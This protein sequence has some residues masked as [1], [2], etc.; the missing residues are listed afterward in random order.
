MGKAEPGKGRE[1][2][3]VRTQFV[4]IVGKTAHQPEAL[5]CR[6]QRKQPWSAMLL[7]AQQG[8][9]WPLHS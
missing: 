2:W 8:G 5:K 6:K 9:R 3:A 4:G 7:M 1:V